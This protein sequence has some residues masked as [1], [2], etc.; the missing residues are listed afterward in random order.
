M[1]KIDE[2]TGVLLQYSIMC[3]EII[4]AMTERTQLIS[5]FFSENPSLNSDHDLQELSN[6]FT[7]LCLSI[8]KLDDRINEVGL[9]KTQTIG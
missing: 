2:K 9:D 3:K 1:S 7:R 5:R 4:S 6:H 8:Q